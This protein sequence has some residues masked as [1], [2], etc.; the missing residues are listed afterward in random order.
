MNGATL[1]SFIRSAYNFGDLMPLYRCLGIY[2][3]VAELV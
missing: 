1:I 3:Y 2:C